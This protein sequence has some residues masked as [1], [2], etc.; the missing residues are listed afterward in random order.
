MRPLQ[1]VGTVVEV[2]FVVLAVA[3][4]VGQLLGQPVLVSYV[5][6]GSMEPTIDAGDGFVPLPTAVVG[7]PETGDVVTF[8][9]K[10]LQGGGLVTHRIG[11][12]EAAEAYR[13]L[14]DD[15]ENALQVLLVW[16]SGEPSV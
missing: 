1:T 3:L 15:P 9:A 11:C 14:D 7:P 12:E 2:A 10:Q 6:T 5:R 4:V 8:R 13:L 16:P